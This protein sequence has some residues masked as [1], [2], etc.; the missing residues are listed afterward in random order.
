MDYITKDSGKRESF[1]SGAVRDTQEGKPRYDLIPPAPLKRVAELYA[2]GAEK[3]SAHNWTRGM[4]TS[5]MLASAMRHLEQY[6][7]GDVDEDHLA[8][9]VFN[10]FG[11]MHFQNTEWDD[12]FDWSAKV[13]TEVE[14]ISPFKAGDW[15][16]DPDGDVGVVAEVNAA[17]DC[18]TV[19]YNDKAFSD[20]WGAEQLKFAEPT[21]R[22]Q[23]GD[24]VRVINDALEGVVVDRI[25][26]ED[27]WFPVVVK[28]GVGD[29]DQFCDLQLELV[30]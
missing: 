2:R 6:R 1:E 7:A 8:A 18:V 16:Q 20:Q 4:G 28:F 26:N 14:E 25:S 23:I 27:V 12:T 29:F 11:I 15:V 30:E 21:R 10:I 22:F 13:E 19:V 5:R 24:R 17:Y 9:V 3:Y